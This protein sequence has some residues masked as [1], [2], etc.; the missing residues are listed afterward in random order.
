VLRPPA[1]RQAVLDRVIAEL[2]A[3]RAR[4]H[5][6]G[7]TLTEGMRLSDLG[8]GSLD[9]AEVISNLEAA[10]DVDPFAE[11]VAI[12]SIT[13]VASLC[14]AYAGCLADAPAEAD[15]LDRELRAIRQ[16]RGRLDP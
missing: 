12:T 10:F 16:G 2:S 13:D 15:D 3:V 6:D 9:L 8:I 14:D 4:R 5:D 1:D 7:L 11:R